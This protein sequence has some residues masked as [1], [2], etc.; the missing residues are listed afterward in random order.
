MKVLYKPQDPRMH[1]SGGV[2]TGIVVLITVGLG[3]VE[4]AGKGNGQTLLK[5]YHGAE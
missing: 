2:I 1:R 5:F 4:E 3:A